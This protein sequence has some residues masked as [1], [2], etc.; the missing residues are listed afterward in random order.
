MRKNLLKRH[1]RDN[2]QCP[3]C[4]PD[5]LSIEYFDE[6][7]I[8]LW[9]SFPISP[10]HILVIPKEHYP[11]IFDVPSEEQAHLF[12]L[13]NKAKEII[14]QTHSPDGFNI[15]INSGTAAGQTVPHAHIHVIPRYN[16]DVED[17]RGGVR[18][19]IPEKAKYWS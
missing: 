12:K 11:N 14:S 5:Q 7:G 8:I 4:T 16:A 3:F 2:S 15:G 1:S 10:G 6:I 19:I 13:I 9:D 18:W 17:P